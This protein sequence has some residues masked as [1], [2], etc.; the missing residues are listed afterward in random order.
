[1]SPVSHAHPASRDREIEDQVRTALAARH[2]PSLRRLAVSSFQG[3][4]TVLG[5]VRS[6]YEKQLVNQCCQEVIGLGQI[7]NHVAVDDLD[8]RNPAIAP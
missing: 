1:M 4:V 3:A 2:V 7:E 5:N 6:F 8:R